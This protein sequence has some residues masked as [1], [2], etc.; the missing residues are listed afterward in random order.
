[1]SARGVAIR[2]LFAVPICCRD[3]PACVETAV[4]IINRDCVGGMGRKLKWGRWALSASVCAAASGCIVGVDGEEPSATSSI[5]QPLDTIGFYPGRGYVQAGDIVA[6]DCLVPAAYPQDPKLTIEPVKAANTGG[7][8]VIFSLSQVTSSEE[9][10]KKLN[11][12]ASVSAKALV[13]SGSAKFSFA[14]DTKTDDSS[15]TLLASVIVRNTSWTVPPGVKLGK[16]A[17][18]LL[19]GG[20]VERFKE[21]CGDSFV[22]SY[23]TGGEFHAFIQVQTSSKEEKETIS[24][25]VQGNYLTVSGAADFNS[26]M[27][28]IVKNSKTVV[29]SYQIGGSGIDTAPCIDVACVADRVSKFTDAVAR[30]PV[31]FDADFAKYSV[32]E[33]PTDASSMLDVS[34]RLDTMAN[35]NTQRNSTRDQLYK[36]LDAQSRP[37][38]YAMYAPNATLGQVTAAISTLGE[39]LTALDNA[40]KGCARGTTCLMPTLSAIA[41]QPPPAVPSPRG[42][43][44]I[45][46]YYSPSFYLTG[47]LMMNETD[48]S[49]C[50]GELAQAQVSDYRSSLDDFA[51]NIVPGLMPN[52]GGN[53]AFSIQPAGA[54]NSFLAM[55]HFRDFCG[56]GLKFRSGPLTGMRA[57]EATFFIEPGLNGKPNTVSLRRWYDPAEPLLNQTPPM[58]YTNSRYYVTLRPDWASYV[59][60]KPVEYRLI[61]EDQA[62]AETK[63][64]ASWYLEAL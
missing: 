63:D 14:Q 16:E 60:A 22:R 53:R 62:G 6:S 40:L 45:R 37:E 30:N 26:K 39:N 31:V 35:L 19:R 2:R 12:N 50:V 23:T 18:D 21:R 47:G 46:S 41:V 32:L 24:A 52:V 15:V 42:L 28:S 34:V 33:L 7:Q 4:N 36:F 58:T 17:Y 56:K 10:Q 25:S 59:E 57:I 1:M 11:I 38:R 13:G 44:V 29:K 20:F 8:E 51:F 64:A 55:T 48:S 49:P 5:G 3:L 54:P 43:T 9:I 27:Q 61:D